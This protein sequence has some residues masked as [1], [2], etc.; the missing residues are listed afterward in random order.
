MAGAYTNVNLSQLPVPNIVEQI[1]F[2][3]ILAEIISDFITRMASAGVVYD[4]LL[5]SDPLY[6][7]AEVAAYREVILRQRANESAK[8]VMLALALGADLDNLGANVDVGRLLIDAGD[9]N[10]VPPVLPTYESDDDFRARIQLSFEGYTTAGS[11]GSYVFHALSADGDVK[12]AS[13]VSP[14]PGVVNVYV[15]SRAGNGSAPA[16]LVAKVN[17][18]L[19]AEDIRP[20]T[21][22]V[23]VASATI[24]PYSIT[25]VLTLY[26]GPDAEVVR[27][28]AMASL[29]AYV[30]SV[31]R[32][33]YDVTR[34]GIIGALV[35]PGVQNVSLTQPAADIIVGDSQATFCTARAITNAVA[36]NV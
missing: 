18:A 17:A 31:A 25:A 4:A 14:T 35:Q 27:Q 26:P 22:F 1:D 20:M 13:A 33:G 16:P 34:A 10:A 28:A 7:L 2:E 8:G 30:A 32:I 3:S 11:E 15:L 29:D 36:T 9:P 19:N 12:D 23:T 24:I 21:D 5:E 6:K